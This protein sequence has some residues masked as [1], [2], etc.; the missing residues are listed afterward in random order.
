MSSDAGANAW[1]ALAPEERQAIRA[2]ISDNLLEPR[3]DL[4]NCPAGFICEEEMQSNCTRIRIATAGVFG[5]GD[6]HAGMW[7]P[8]N[9]TQYRNCP[10]G[11]Y[12]PSP[13]ELILCPQGMFCPH[14][15]LQPEI[16][17][18]PCKAGSDTLQRR[19]YGYVL[20]GLLGAVLLG[21]IVLTMV[22]RYK[23][24]LYE[25][26]VELSGRKLD[27]IRI[28]KM[29]Q[30]RAA[31]VQ[32]VQHKLFRIQER[33]SKANAWKRDNGVELHMDSTDSGRYTFDARA[34]FNA[35]DSDHDG[36]LN[37]SE[38]QVVLALN[39]QQLAEFVRRMNEL[40]GS[41]VGSKKVSRKC[42]VRHFLHVLEETSHFGPTPS[43]VESLFDD[44]AGSADASEVEFEKFYVSPLSTFLSDPQINDMVARFRRCL[45]DT[46]TSM[47]RF[48]FT[49]QGSMRGS[50]RDSGSLF[51]DGQTFIGRTLIG[52]TVIGQTTLR[53]QS[54]PRQVFVEHY[55]EILA[56]V[57]ANP[58]YMPTSTIR[59]DG[60][61]DTEEDP[62]SVDLTFEDL[63]LAVKLGENT[64]NVVNH[65]SGRIEA[66]TMTALMGGS[67]AGKTS[68]LNALCGRAFY[69]E[70]T[71]TI[72]V[73]GNVATIEDHKGA[74][75]FV[76]Q[77]DIV[78][79]ELTVKEN[80]MFSGRF[81]L[82][83]DTP[84]W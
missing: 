68:L 62:D 65:V 51:R 52:R 73:N 24:D 39:D 61:A 59:P 71:G 23:R 76:P 15:T 31:Q 11:H 26:F 69:G 19:T 16:T 9:E 81:S 22:R 60:G 17:C 48:S 49:K 40:D 7:C 55:P 1:E 4:A 74:T 63:S 47:R 18:P 42:F 54:V 79:A 56:Q 45:P 75:G 3:T 21:Y 41:A 6:V 58:D 34:L 13:D 33:L 70:T 32:K 2:N 10:V 8:D 28:L 77:D 30:E 20:I 35:L 43:E 83:P 38:L 14:K 46:R 72:K 36:S 29:R 44:I 57:T 53:A 82:P 80:L 84:L 67:G 12:C 78:F 66:A 27:S 64:V 37:Y 50:M 25:H 5:F